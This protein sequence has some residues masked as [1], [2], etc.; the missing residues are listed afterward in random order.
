M[1]TTDL[2]TLFPL[3]ALDTTSTVEDWEDFGS[4]LNVIVQATPWTV[5]DFLVFGEE[6]FHDSLERAADIFPTLSHERLATLQVLGERF[7]PEKRI[8]AD[9]LSA[10]MFEEVLRFDDEDA[11]DLLD[12]AVL[13]GWNRDQLRAAARDKKRELKGDPIP[14]PPKPLTPEQLARRQYAT[15]F[16]QNFRQLRPGDS[17]TVSYAEA[18]ILAE[19]ALAEADL[20]G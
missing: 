17:V 15:S 1:T 11:L 2:E 7:P 6:N 18:E 3:D 19:L 20:D 16:I 12:R 9:V 8:H 10:S 4:L 13:E 5:A 14:F